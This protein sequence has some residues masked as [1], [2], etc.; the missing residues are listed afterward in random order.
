MVYLYQWF[1]FFFKLGIY[2]KMS[3]EAGDQGGDRMN[4]KYFTYWMDYTPED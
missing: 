4:G 2:W 1:D 3:Q